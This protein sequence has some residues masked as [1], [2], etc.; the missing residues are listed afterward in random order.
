MMLTAYVPIVI[1][2]ALV[3]TFAGL[4][5]L[6]SCFLGPSSKAR[7]APIGRRGE[8]V[9][10]EIPHYRFSTALFTLTL[11]FLTFESMNVFLFPWAVVFRRA[12]T[13][14]IVAMTMFIGILLVGFVYAWKKGAQG[15][16]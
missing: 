15:W 1:F 9:P 6:L 13:P 7:H 5:L 3:A 11:L 12:G 10:S 4:A 2:C 14:G 8:S 16:E